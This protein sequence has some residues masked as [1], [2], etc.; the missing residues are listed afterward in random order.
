MLEG[1]SPGHHEDGA[2]G[3]ES[4]SKGDGWAGVDGLSAPA[5]CP[6]RGGDSVGTLREGGST[7]AKGEEEGV[8]AWG[9]T[10][11]KGASRGGSLEDFVSLTGVTGAKTLPGSGGED[12][13][14]AGGTG[15]KGFSRVAVACG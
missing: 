13:A 8:V 4:G 1:V 5:G 6:D 12:V 11:E 3:E 10:G 2:E 7:S 9:L 14:D 15:V